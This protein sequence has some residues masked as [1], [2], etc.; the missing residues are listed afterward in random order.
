MIQTGYLLGTAAFIAAIIYFFAANWGVFTRFHKIGLSAGLLVLFYGFSIGFSRWSRRNF[1]THILL[2]TGCISFGVGTALLGQIYNSHAD[3]YLLFA[4]WLVPA[5]LFAVV[6]RFQ[7]FYVL[8]YVLLQL[9]MW[10][11]I[12]PA[13]VRIH[14]SETEIAISLLVVA[15]IDAL[16]WRL[17]EKQKVK[18]EAV[19]FLSFSTVQLIL[20]SLANSLIFEEH[21]IWYNLLDVVAI[22]GS[23]YYFLK[24]SVQKSYA[25]LTGLFAS[26]FVISKYVELAAE[27]YS[28]AFF[29]FGIF[30]FIM[31]LLLNLAFLKFVNKLTAARHETREQESLLTRAV[32]VSLTVA[33]IVIGC[34]S[35]IGFVMLITESEYAL[36]FI[37]VLMLLAIFLLKKPNPHVRCTFLIIG[38]AIGLFSLL[39]IEEGTISLCYVILLA[40]CWYQSREK[41]ERIFVYTTFAA[42]LLAAFNQFD[43]SFHN[44]LLNA[45]FIHAFL[46]VLQHFIKA[47]K[48]RDYL[49]EMSFLFSFLFLFWLTF[50]KEEVAALYYASN[51]LFFVL[52]TV[53]LFIYI[54]KQQTFLS[55]TS[56]VFW[57]SYLVY[58]YYDVL[59]DF[60][61]KSV[62]LTIVSIL[63]IAGTYWYERKLGPILSSSPSVVRSKTIPILLII[64]LQLAS[65]GFQIVKS[66]LI[67]ANGTEIKLKLAPVDPR[68]LL[69]G[70]YVRLNY[71]ISRPGNLD[72]DYE[73]GLS[74]KKNVQVVLHPDSNGLYA[75]KKLY[76]EGDRVQE[77]EVIINGVLD[78]GGRIIYGIESYFV[79][80]GTG[81][82]VEASARYA[83]VRVGSN[84]DAI[85]VTLLDDR[86]KPV[87][88]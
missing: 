18:S 21:T 41:Y 5:A 74:W 58:K 77:G 39:M 43:W 19:K 25:M 73:D 61:H 27:H 28:E 34:I 75:V 47:H 49:N 81:R 68:S 84:G 42:T 69:Q 87:P 67:L 65:M 38:L 6:T 33:G 13:S 36:F 46:F 26:L 37:S 10:F 82:E 86:N 16:I 51:A 35:I 7:A 62:T 56:M 2:V 52:A 59:W 45:F 76:Q 29:L 55:L 9:A 70:D 83:L 78:R 71:E 17:N 80:E 14:Q 22:G 4:I 11:F 20:L 8:S 66:E 31:L 15:L 23:F 3:S 54:K 63:L 85:L 48:V 44:A 30:F 1:L 72:S 88:K 40:V 50:F 53:S 24:R 12:F 57:F 79:P 64:L 60:L 32:G